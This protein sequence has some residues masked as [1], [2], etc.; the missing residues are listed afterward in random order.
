[1]RITK[2]MAC[3]LAVVMLFIGFTGCAAPGKAEITLEVYNW[4]EYISDGSDGSLNVI[5][6]FE[7]QTGI[8]VHYTNFA[9]NEE[10][11]TKIA[12]GGV[13]YDIIIPS[14]YMVAR[15]IEE[16]ML[17]K[18]DF[19]NI[20][21]ANGVGDNFK[22]L[23]YDPKNEYSVPYMSGVV[24]IIYNKAM[25]SGKIDSWNALWDEQYKGQI[26]MFDN[27]RDAF[28]ISLLRLG[29]SI[30]TTNAN[31]IAEAAEA[32]KLQKPLV[33]AYVMDQIFNKMGSGEAALAP[34]YAGDAIT[35]MAENSDLAFVIPKEGTNFF[36]DAMVIPTGCKNKQAAE[37]FINFMCKPEISAAN[38]EYIGYSTPVPD[39]IG[40]LDLDPDE[41]AIAYPD[42]EVL[43]NTE[44]FRHLPKDTNE[45]IN[46]YWIEI[47]GYDES[48]NKWITPVLLAAALAAAVVIIIVRSRKRKRAIY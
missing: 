19:N 21:N 26:L 29:Y 38:A 6:E 13:Q 20:P 5:A 43:A 23:E 28:G 45:L 8:S 7:K 40:L 24:G 32:L 11:Y 3:L 34:Y 2:R 16:D 9:N 10:M 15:M 39:A 25:V 30:N 12:N 17:E 36:V 47:K 33:Q 14:D 22:N 4:G 31:E 35:M 18:L 41:M 42:D 44:V 48:A 37:M 1:M 46:Q 27:P